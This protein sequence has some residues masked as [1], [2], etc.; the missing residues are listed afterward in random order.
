MASP[1]TLIALFQGCAR[2][3]DLQYN[4]AKM[5]EQTLRAKEAGAEIIV[6]PEL[7]LTGYCLAAD[8]M[9]SV[10][11]EFN[12]EAFQELSALARETGV[13][14]LYGYPERVNT[15]QGTNYFNSAQ[16]IDREG[17]SLVNHRKVHLWIDEDGYEKV[18]T[19]AKGFSNIVEYCGLKIGVLICYDVEFPEAVRTLAL[20]GANLI[21][22]P[23]AVKTRWMQELTEH[24]IPARAYE[25]AVHVAYVNNTGSIFAG[26]SV[27]CGVNGE[28]IVSAGAEEELML[29]SIER[30]VTKS[31]HLRDRRPDLYD[32]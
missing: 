17:K 13:G 23:T 30:G 3:K 24:I 21:L 20:R 32:I 11:Q 19:Q 12:G 26:Q 28:S 15:D 25:N 7:F 6:F 2:S 10:A 4:L 27:C 29:A 8:D 9:K 31:H 16:L 1:A 18:F 22:V 14:I 5:R